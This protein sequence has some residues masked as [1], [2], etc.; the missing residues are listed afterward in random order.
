[1]LTHTNTPKLPQVSTQTHAHTHKNTPKQPH[2]RVRTHTNTPKQPHSHAQTHA[3]KHMH[4]NTSKQPHIR[5][6]THINT[7]KLP[8]TCARSRGP[9]NASER[10]GGGSIISRPKEGVGGICIEMDIGLYYWWRLWV[11]SNVTEHFFRPTT[12]HL[13]TWWTNIQSYYGISYYVRYHKK[14]MQ[15]RLGLS[16]SHL[17]ILDRDG[18]KRIVKL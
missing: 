17:V 9:R 12:T 4:T 6:R 14:N 1:M 2:I 7:P 3:H 5:G 11:L 13:H 15:R 10:G 16:G 8:Y 18:W